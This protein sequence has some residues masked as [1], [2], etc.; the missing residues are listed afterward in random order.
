MVCQGALLP[1]V[2]ERLGHSRTSVTADRYGHLYTSL[3]AAL[4]SQLGDVYRVS[5]IAKVDRQKPWRSGDAVFRCRSVVAQR[6]L[7]Y[8]GRPVELASR[9]AP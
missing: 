2:K 6:R 4:T 9:L 3:S 7:R 5:A 1:L 8:P